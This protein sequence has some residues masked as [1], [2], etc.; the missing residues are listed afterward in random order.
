MAFGAALGR[1]PRV[2]RD[3]GTFVGFLGLAMVYFWR[4]FAIDPGDRRWIQRGDFTD[5]FYPWARFAAD[6]LGAG[7]LPLW[8]PYVLGGHPFQADPQTATLYPV[9]LLIAFVFGSGGLAFRELELEIPLHL[10]LAAF[11]A[12]LFA[13]RVYGNGAA[14]IVTGISYGFGGFLTSYPVQQL[15]I[16]RSAAWIPWLLYCVERS[17]GPKRSPRA[18]VALAIIA[19]LSIVAGHSQTSMFGLYL[20]AAYLVVRGRQ[21]GRGWG[22]IARA[23]VVGLGG[24]VALAAVQIV[25]TIEFAGVSTRAR[26]SFDDAA[27]GYELKALPGILLSSWRGERAL[28]AGY[29]GYALALVQV[30]RRGPTTHFWLIVAVLALLLSVGGHTFAFNIVYWLLPGWAT[31]RDQERLAV[32]WSLAIAMMAGGGLVAVRHLSTTEHR[33]I[34]RFSRLAAVVAIVIVVEVVVAWSFRRD[35]IPN[36]VDSLLDS[37]VYLALIALAWAAAHWYARRRGA[38][39]TVIVVCGI[40]SL[41]LFSTGIDANLSREDPNAI[42]ARSPLFDVARQEREPYR[43]RSDDDRQFP[44][45]WAAIWQTPTMTGDSPIQIRRIRELVASGAEW[46]LWQLF[47]VKYLASAVERNDAGLELVARDGESRL[48]RVRYSLPRAW[49]VT[50]ARILPNGGRI[51]DVLDLQIHPGDVAIVEEEP[52]IPIRPGAARS[53]VAVTFER[54]GEMTVHIDG[55]ANSLLVVADAWYPGWNAWIDGMPAPILRTNYAFRGVAVSAGRH[56]V[57]MRFEP[58]SLRLGAGISALASCLLIAVLFVPRRR[59][60]TSH[61]T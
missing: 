45:N 56:V 7:R 61:V 16:L 54:P 15:A 5:Q 31:F 39:V 48:Y 27:Y 46:R 21:S 40:V 13:R 34:S 1:L 37:A 12:F 52:S 3:G 44:P 43:V 35:R 32:L 57:E 18:A 6:E 30:W 42:G 33:V 9:S 23:G 53:D 49:A 55:A 25:P 10:A 38:V 24:G 14:G 17:I 8:N 47:N 50:D 29:V 26:L 28:Y 22:A 60:S 4:L 41:D 20:S 19:A 2:V 11:G 59:A 36:P 58:R 51:E